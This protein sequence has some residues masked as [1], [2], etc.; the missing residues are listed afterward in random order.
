MC[1]CRYKRQ[2]CQHIQAWGKLRHVR[3]QHQQ[4]AALSAVAT[5]AVTG[6]HYR[7]QLLLRCV[8]GWRVAAAEGVELLAAAAGA[9]R[10]VRQRQAL[11]AWWQYVQDQ[12]GPL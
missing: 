4:R 6:Q 1:V 3:Q 11:L 10:S 8:C 5:W 12:V 7:R 2:T 9:M